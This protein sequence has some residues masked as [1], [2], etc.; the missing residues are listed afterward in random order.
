[1]L[2]LPIKK[3]WFYMIL[4][5]EKREEYRD[6]KPYYTTR[7]KIDIKTNSIVLMENVADHMAQE[8]P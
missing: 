7:L 6:I 1:M 3:K 4:T 2:V 8:R 5:G